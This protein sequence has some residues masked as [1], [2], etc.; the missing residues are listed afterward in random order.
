MFKATKWDEVSM[1]LLLF[2]LIPEELILPRGE[3]KLATQTRKKK[4]KH[5]KYS[6]GRLGMGF[7]P[8]LI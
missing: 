8:D 3:P 5:R 4:K 1:E 7:P 2:G 6:K